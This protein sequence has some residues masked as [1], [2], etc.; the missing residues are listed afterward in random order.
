MQ[1]LLS[2]VY[3]IRDAIFGKTLSEPHG[4]NVNFHFDG[5]V[6]DEIKTSIPPRVEMWYS[7]YQKFLNPIIRANFT[8]AEADKIINGYHHPV[9]TIPFM[10]E[11]LKKGDLSDHPVPHD[12]HYLRARKMAA[13]AFRPPRPIRPVHF[14]DL[15]FYNWNWHPNVEEPYYSNKR[16]QEYVQA[17]HTLGL[18]PDARM[19]FG[20]LRDY[21]FMDT[22]HYLH[23]IKR[24]EISNPKTLWPLMKIH[25][26]PALTGT[27]EQKIRVIYGVSK[28]H[29][30]PQCMFFWPLFRHYIENDTDPLL[31]GFETILG[32]MMKLNSLMH[33]L[34]FQ[35]FVTVDWSG[36]D[37][38]SLFSIQREIFDDWRTYF[39]FSNGYIPTVWYPNST[40]DPIQLERL[41][42]WQRD[43]CFN[44]PF[45]M[46]DKSVYRR[47]FRAIP[48]G[49]F[50]TQFLDSHYNYI[51][52]LTIL[53][54][55]GFDITIE[56]I[57]ILVQGDDSLKNLIFFIPA[58]QHDNFK[59]EFQRLATYYFDHVARPEKTEI[60][61]SPQG[62]T[63]LGYTNNNGFPTRDP[64]KLMAQL[65]HPRQVGERW[66]SVL[67]AKCAGFAYASA[68][69]Y[70]KVTATLKTVYYKLAA[71]GFSPAAL[72]TQ[73]D[74]VLFGEAKFQVPTDH[75]PTAEEV[76]RHLRVP[77]KRTEEDSES[78]FPMKHFLDFA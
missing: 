64:I 6:T 40:A 3:S 74:I 26:K 39:D 5:Y 76:Q 47:L 17:A 65:Y 16:A 23:Q 73:R 27:D 69:N 8:G 11:N 4:L 24:N 19:S 70:P 21:V 58:N 25:V 32:G 22:R 78:Y 43:A 61:N 13:D 36:F 9:A 38:R 7:D 33:R 50:V 54:A 62:V 49:L 37:L 18:T 56:R 52:L 55:M 63:V 66:K 14:A 75:F 48:S 71:K 44:M 53:S 12:E 2:A 29:V 15:R 51:M 30:L 72:R 34:Y 35:T 20:N 31:W 28:R 77:Y 41:W 42:N 68:Y 57:R 67:M 45:V 46:P 60:Y 10:V 1:T 59:A